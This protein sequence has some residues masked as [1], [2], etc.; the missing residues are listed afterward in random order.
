VE[1]DSHGR[2][3]A[4]AYCRQGEI[5]TGGGGTT[6]N[7]AIA[8]SRPHKGTLGNLVAWAVS[9]SDSGATVTAQVLCARTAR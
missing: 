9:S 3:F 7:G 6:D 4:A 5:V 1:R 8:S 2:G